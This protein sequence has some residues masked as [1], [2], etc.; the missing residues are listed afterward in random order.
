MQAD[1]DHL[2]G[3]SVIPGDLTERCPGKVSLPYVRKLD[4]IEMKIMGSAPGTYR[5]SSPAPQAPES[6]N[7][8][9]LCGVVVPVKTVPPAFLGQPVRIVPDAFLV[10]TMSEKRYMF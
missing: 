3:Y 6:R 8:F 2:H 4:I 5:E 9:V 10:R 1:S 7:P